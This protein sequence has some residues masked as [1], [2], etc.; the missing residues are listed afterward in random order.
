[1]ATRHEWFHTRTR[2]HEARLTRYTLTLTHESHHASHV[3]RG[4]SLVSPGGAMSH[5]PQHRPYRAHP[6]PIMPRLSLLSGWCC[7]STRTLHKPHSLCSLLSDRHSLRILQQSSRLAAVA[8]APDGLPQTSVARTAPDGL[9]MASL[10]CLPRRAQRDGDK[11]PAE[12]ETRTQFKTSP[13]RQPSPQPSTQ[14][15]TPTPPSS[16]ARIAGPRTHSRVQ[17]TS[18]THANSSR[19]SLPPTAPALSPGCSPQF[20]IHHAAQPRV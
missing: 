2:G 3:H 14:T 7:C 19:A 17:L 11:P 9:P 10:W 6:S 13:Q 4:P 8:Q 18:S 16:L 20:R 5:S 12:H 1:M 15:Q